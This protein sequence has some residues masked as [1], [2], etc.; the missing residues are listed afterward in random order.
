MDDEFLYSQ[1]FQMSSDAN[2]RKIKLSQP[3]VKRSIVYGI[4]Y[5][6]QPQLVL[7]SKTYKVGFSQTGAKR[8]LSYGKNTRR[9]FI[10]EHDNALWLETHIKRI[11]KEKFK[12]VMG[13]EYFE[14]NENDIVEEFRRIV[15]SVNGTFLS[16]D[17]DNLK[18]LPI[19]ENRKLA[20][21]VK[22]VDDNFEKYHYRED[23]IHMKETADLMKVYY[24]SNPEIIKLWNK[25]NEWYQ[26]FKHYFESDHQ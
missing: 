16:C 9:L 18:N 7:G 26:E 8:I 1:R 25:T 14:G 23:R 21:I 12:L 2:A 3:K 6:I 22:K 11:F 24:P 4:V 10:V 19:S 20:R 17:Y 5:L 13:T 15:T